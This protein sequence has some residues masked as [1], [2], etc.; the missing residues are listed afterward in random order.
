MEY[1]CST[2]HKV[3]GEACSE[4]EMETTANE[5][6]RNICL[7]HQLDAVSVRFFVTVDHGIRSW[8]AQREN[9]HTGIDPRRILGIWTSTFFCLWNDTAVLATIQCSEEEHK[10]FM[11]VTC[12]KALLPWEQ[13]VHLYNLSRWLCA[14][15]PL[16]SVFQFFVVVRF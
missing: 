2:Y 6:N 15:L 3:V 1:S 13:C 4:E 7:I 9:R 16:C 11:H 5:L 14:T 8:G 12:L 10:H